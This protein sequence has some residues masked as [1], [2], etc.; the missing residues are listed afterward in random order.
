MFSPVIRS[1]MWK[2][3]PA[4]SSSRAA[5]SDIVPVRPKP[6]PIIF[7][8]FLPVP[9]PLRCGG[10]VTDAR[11]PRD[12]SRD[13]RGAVCHP[14]LDA[15]RLRGSAEREGR[16]PCKSGGRG[17]SLGQEGGA[18]RTENG[19]PGPDIS[20]VSSGVVRPQPVSRGMVVVPAKAK[21]FAKSGGP[22]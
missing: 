11:S 22:L 10:G 21:P 19:F 13:R 17:P 20:A 18:M 2:H 1:I 8:L 9:V 6:T 15:G 7:M 12:Q 3:G 16:I 14:A 5:L 4:P